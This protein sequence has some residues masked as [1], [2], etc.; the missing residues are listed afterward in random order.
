MIKKILFEQYKNFRILF[1]NLSSVM[2]LILG[3]LSLILIIGFAYSGSDVH[4]INI[5]VISS[6][7]AVLEPAFGNFSSFAEIYKYEDSSSCIKEINNQQMHICLEFSEDFGENSESGIP[8]GTIVFYFDNS[9]KALSN[10]I[11]DSLSRY[12]GTESEKI[13]IESAKTIFGNIQSLVVY[14]EQKNQDIYLLIDESLNI[15]ADLIDRHNRLIEIKDEFDPI[16]ND[17]KR[18]QSRLNDL[19][20]GI[21]DSYNG[22][23]NDLMELDRTLN[24]LEYSLNHVREVP[25]LYF[26]EEDGIYRLAENISSLGNITYYNLSQYNYTYDNNNIIVFANASDENNS[27]LNMTLPDETES[28]GFAAE[29][30][31][32][33]VEKTRESIESM[34]ESS[35]RYFNYTKEQKIEFDKAVILLDNVNET[36]ALDIASTE[37]YIIKI[38][39]AADRV[40]KIQKELN[41]S[42]S[43]LAKLEPSLAEKLVKPILQ[44]YEPVLP[45]I[46]NIKLAFPGMLAIILIFISILF[47]NIV[48]ISEINSKAF[49]R[50]MIA[51]VNSLIFVAGLI[52]T[53][54]I[55]VLFQIFV[56]L[57]VAQF[58]FG[59]N[60][61]DVI[62]PVL[63]VILL[64]SMLF[65]CFGMI[66]S[67][68]LK[69]PQTSI[70]TTTFVALGFFLFSDAVAPLETMPY[71]AA[72]IASYNPFVLASVAFKKIII[73]NLPIE[74]VL[75]QLSMLSIFLG[76]A[77]VT[78]LLVSLLRL[79]ER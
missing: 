39:N 26:Y 20:L 33:S 65:I 14:L 15:K 35:F 46:E 19:S 76:I 22:F 6:D 50:N 29:A 36:L 54:I 51:P 24:D 49:Y 11:V 23:I 70:L 60:V 53:N 48:T 73:F 12:F 16:Y 75:P 25:Q 21:N 74:S 3:P 69:N 13:S 64:V 66:L 8:S 9:R 79:K 7:Y 5:G 1:R 2:L 55:V 31:L 18:L 59:I 32:Y 52:I 71:L 78:L 47:S 40:I 61:F 42:I 45:G 38:D 72:A 57:L 58:R 30:A 44:S 43:E 67:I 56:L 77:L 27:A 28:I 4:S 63:V 68:L 10:K 41:S 62:I 34:K 37:E 17:S